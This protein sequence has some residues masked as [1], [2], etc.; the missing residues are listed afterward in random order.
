MAMRLLFLLLL[1]GTM[2]VAEPLNLEQVQQLGRLRLG[3]TESEL[4]ELGPPRTIGKPVVE[5]ATGLTVQRRSYPSKGLTI[6][7]SREKDADAWRVERFTAVPPNSWKTPQG[8]GLGSP[9]EKVRSTYA[10]LLDPES[11]GSSQLVVGSIYGGI[12]FSI[13]K[14]KVSRIFVGA[15]AE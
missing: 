8:I 13:K 3:L 6:T 11:S 12:V 1:L 4:A 9:A 10:S 14:G 5:G 2:V 15:A 7:W